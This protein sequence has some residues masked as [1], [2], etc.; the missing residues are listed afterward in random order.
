MPE[1]TVE[2]MITMMRQEWYDFTAGS[3]T[4]DVNVR[5]FIQH[6]YTPYEGD[7][8]FLVGPTPRTVKLWEKVMELMKVENKNGILEAETEKP[9]TITAFG[10]GYLDQEN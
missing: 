7:A 4:T 3:W 9:S 8:S 1:I 6:N 2:R 10:P 5:S